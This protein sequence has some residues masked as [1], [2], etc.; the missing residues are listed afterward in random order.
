MFER[1]KRGIKVVVVVARTL[2]RGK[3][4]PAREGLPKQT[5]EETI[6]QTRFSRSVQHARC[7]QRGM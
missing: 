7:L 4:Q 5:V 6:E 3:A 2:V 1:C